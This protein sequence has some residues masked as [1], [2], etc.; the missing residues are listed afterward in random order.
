MKTDPKFIVPLSIALL[1]KEKG[2]SERE[3]KKS[4]ISYDY[5]DVVSGELNAHC[6]KTREEILKIKEENPCAKFK[7]FLKEMVYAPCFDE[8]SHWI[9][10]N[11]LLYVTVIPTSKGW[12]YEIYDVKSGVLH[13]SSNT[14]F[15]E[16][17]Y[18]AYQMG[19]QKTLNLC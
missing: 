5:Y 4:I 16:S 3:T 12:T 15:N 2:Y 17:Y 6:L 14:E 8:L 10:V 18:V 1:A 9:S 11:F 19:L 13:I 7:D